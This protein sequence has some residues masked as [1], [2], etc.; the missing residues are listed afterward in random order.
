MPA[1]VPGFE[2]EIQNGAMGGECD[3]EEP[4]EGGGESDDEDVDDEGMG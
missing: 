1:G 4:G 3:S 2:N